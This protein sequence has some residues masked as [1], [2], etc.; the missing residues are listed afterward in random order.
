MVCG[1]IQPDTY[2][3]VLCSVD[4]KN[5]QANSNISLKDTTDINLNVKQARYI[6]LHFTGRYARE[7]KLYTLHTY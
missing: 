7:L 6:K 5:W 1:D 3:Q 2:V 4:G